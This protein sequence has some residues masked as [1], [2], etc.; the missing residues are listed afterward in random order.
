MAETHRHSA[1]S[2][3][4]VNSW[5][6]GELASSTAD[7]VPL[8][9]SGNGTTFVCFD[10]LS[11]RPELHFCSHTPPNATALCRPPIATPSPFRDEPEGRTLAD[12]LS[13]PDRYST[14]A[15]FAPQILSGDGL[16]S[17]EATCT[18]RVF[19]EA[20][21]FSNSAKMSTAFKLTV[22]GRC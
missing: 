12:Y 15:K 22:W 14:Q 13:L 8:T 2:S 4:W 5:L 1:A 6:V 21:H 17:I 18:L 19:N 9:V 11:P 20:C 3:A 7:R 16:V 10:T